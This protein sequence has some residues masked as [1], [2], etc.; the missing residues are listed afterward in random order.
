MMLV[1]SESHVPK[2]IS[3]EIIFCGI[4]RRVITIH[5]RHRQTDRRTDRQLIMAMPPHYHATLFVW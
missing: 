1:S 4:P 5:Q 3:R 2:L